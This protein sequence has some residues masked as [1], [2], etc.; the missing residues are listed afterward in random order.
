M[1]ALPRP[2]RLAR[3]I[4][5]VSTPDALREFVLGDLEERFAATVRRSGGR[6]ARRQYWDQA[7]GLLRHAPAL[8]RRRAAGVARLRGVDMDRIWRDWRLALRTIWR[9]PGY[10]LITA[11]TL[12]LAIGANTLLFSIANPLVLRELPIRN[13]DRLGWLN[14]TSAEREIERGRASMPELFEWRRTLTSF[15]ELAAYAQ[16]GGTLVGHG[17]ARR[18]QTARVTANLPAVWGLIAVRGRLFHPGEDDPGRPLVGVVSH[19]FW[20]EAFAGDSSIV[21]GT[22]MLDGQPIAIVGVMEPAIEFGNLSLIDMWVPLPLAPE[23]PRDRRALTVVGRLAPGQTVADADAELQPVFA[24]QAREHPLIYA[25]WQAQVHDTRAVVAAPDTWVILGLLTVVVVFVLLIACANLANLVMARLATRRGEL[26]VRRALGASR[27]QLVRPLLAESLLLGLIGGA[28]GV[29]LAHGGLRLVNAASYDP[30]MRQIGI[31]GNVLIFAA[32]L[33]LLTPLVFA[34]YPA[35]IAGRDSGAGPLQG[36]RT[37]GTRAAARRRHLLIGTQVALAL[38]LLVLAALVTQSMLY[39]RRI[40][41]GYDARALLT[42]RFDLPETRYPD[43]AS[44][45]AFV[46]RLQAQLAAL[47]GA[48]GAAAMSHLPVIERDSA[49]SLSGTLRDGL[50]D[51]ERPWAS[52]FIVTAGF[53]GA[54]GIDLLAG[55]AIEARD[56]G[57]ADQ[58]AVL[59]RLAAERYF[60]TVA[61]AV[62]RRIVIHDA[63]LGE[64]PVTIVGVVADTRDA[65]VT[66]TSPQIYVPFHQWPRPSIRAVVRSAD[67]AARAAEAQAAMRA[68]DPEIAVADL[69]LVSAI[70]DEELASTTII[71]GLFVSYALLALLLAAGG[72][73]GVI[74]YSVAQRRREIGVRLALGAT[75]QSIARMVVREGLLV[76]GA[77]AG[78]GLLLAMGLARLSASVLYGIDATDPPTFLGVLGVIVTVALLATW[79]PAVRAMRVD[80]ATTLRAE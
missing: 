51:E 29:A 30:F 24:S 32:L 42:F 49:R 18:I 35:V 66:R 13:P 48:T 36:V 58:V 46:D 12:A 8:R 31:D 70:M 6:E 75:R 17:D 72:L 55:R 64:R 11:V 23:E 10:A 73:F 4:A 40:D 28:A 50:S 34:V 47:P 53:F 38:S 33:S 15:S 76:T 79:A 2:P 16:G 21:G 52:C 78:I 43:S 65:Q 63:A 1:T 80:P 26:D 9:S 69:K 59:N 20:R 71:N 25:G 7:A 56:V 19:R 39:L 41:P 44:R 74:S 54:A 67:P 68:L 60:N 57:R 27:W 61:N 3:L 22:L 45:L 77:G 14:L 62:G 37:T 5:W